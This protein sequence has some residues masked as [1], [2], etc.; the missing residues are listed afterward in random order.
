MSRYALSVGLLSPEGA[1]LPATRS[2]NKRR[3][4]AFV[5]GCALCLTA[6]E[7]ST[8]SGPGIYQSYGPSVGLFDSDASDIASANDAPD[9]AT[10]NATTSS[11]GVDGD[12]IATVDVVEDVPAVT[13]PGVTPDIAPADVQP[14]EVQ[15]TEDTGDETDPGVVTPPE[16]CFGP[17][18]CDDLDPCTKDRCV[19]TTNKCEYEAIIGCCH[20]PSDCPGHGQCTVV[21]CTDNVCLQETIWPCCLL[22]TQ[23]KDTDDCTDDKCVPLEGGGAECQ[24]TPAPGCCS[25][26]M[27]NDFSVPV[28]IAGWT[29]TETLGGIGWEVMGARFFSPPSSLHMGITSEPSFGTEEGHVATAIELPEVSL[30]DV[31]SATLRFRVYVD[32]EPCSPLRK[33]ADLL[34]LF[35]DADIASNLMLWHKCEVESMAQWTLAEV[36]L[37]KLREQTFTLRLDFDS[38][39]DALNGGQGVFVDDLTLEVCY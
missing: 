38:V 21:S 6:C 4:L 5:A 18:D 29:L 3:I 28:D 10:D 23:C 12:S 36:D 39:D 30:G 13:D 27:T 31:A 9:D 8:L 15:P 25:T 35:A 32:V 2:I 37:T 7:P 24:S 17:W 11:D 14:T 33:G 26:L 1:G 20:Q 34:R 19:A 16:L 22:D